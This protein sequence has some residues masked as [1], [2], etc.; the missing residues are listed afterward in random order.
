MAVKRP[1][2]QR[3]GDRLINPDS[4]KAQIECDH[5]VSPFDRLALEMEMVWGIDQLPTLV[6]PEMARRY[7]AAVAH[8]NETIRESD[9]AA[10]V[11]AV[12][13]CCRGLRTMDATA[14]EAGAQPATGDFWEYELEA[15]PGREAFRF[16]VMRDSHEWQTSKAKRPD[17]EFYTLREVAI[18]LQA[19]AGKFAV[20]EVKDKFP[21]AEITKVTVDPVNWDLGGDKIPF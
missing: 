2:R 16:A 11:A 14:R 7:G 10:C 21:A 18:A 4:T 19:V 1:R 6:P 12:E 5:A 17:L 15:E 3:K 13:N 8:L 9:T 20:S